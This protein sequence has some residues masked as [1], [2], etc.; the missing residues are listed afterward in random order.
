ML[1]MLG[2]HNG[3]STGAKPGKAESKYKVSLEHTCSLSLQDQVYETLIL[4]LHPRKYYGFLDC[5]TTMTYQSRP[6]NWGCATRR[7]MKSIP[8]G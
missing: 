3:N 7:S 4:T 1:S 6:P 2:A 8:H 5:Q